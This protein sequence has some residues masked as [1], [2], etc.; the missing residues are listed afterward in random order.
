MPELTLCWPVQ[1]EV[2]IRVHSQAQSDLSPLPETHLGIAERLQGLLMK[3]YCLTLARLFPCTP[4]RG[5][6]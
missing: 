1:L 6:T 3:A 5:M 2:A 4:S